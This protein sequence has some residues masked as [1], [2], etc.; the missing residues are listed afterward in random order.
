M[1]W[2]LHIFISLK[3]WDWQFGK[4]YLRWTV[5]RFFFNDLDEQHGSSYDMSWL[6]L[7]DNNPDIK[8][9]KH[10]TYIWLNVKLL[11]EYYTVNWSNAVIREIIFLFSNDFVDLFSR[12]CTSFFMHLLPPNMPGKET[13][14]IFIGLKWWHVCLLVSTSGSFEDNR[15]FFCPKSSSYVLICV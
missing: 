5:G 6:N 14:V 7:V 4:N 11:L 13:Y 2:L 1:S 3:K 8:F 15:N 12:R 10:N 9:E